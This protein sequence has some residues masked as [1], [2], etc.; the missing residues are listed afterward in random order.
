MSRWVYLMGV[1]LALLALAFVL[2]DALLWRP[3]ASQANLR[4]IRQGM[5]L[6]EV[7]AILGGPADRTY[8]IRRFPQH[9]REEYRPGEKW[10]RGWAG[11]RGEAIVNFDEGD[12]VTSTCWDEVEDTDPDP[13]PSPLARLR[14]WL[15][16]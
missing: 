11:S 16:W 13:P 10:T 1:G 6:R 14:A 5:A 2:T 9:M 12:R 15:A 4:R 8:D 7:E 3:E